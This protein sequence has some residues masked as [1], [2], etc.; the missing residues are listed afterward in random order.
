MVS[1]AIAA[2]GSKINEV[3][4]AAFWLSIFALF[5]QI[6]ALLR[7]RLLAHYFGTG[8]ALDVYYAAFKV[9]DLIFVTVASLVELYRDTLIKE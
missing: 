5:S 8:T 7:D 4:R 3:K 2:I 1:A 6:L 9:P